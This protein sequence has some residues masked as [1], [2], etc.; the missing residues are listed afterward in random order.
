MGGQYLCRGIFAF[1]S[2]GL[3]RHSLFDPLIHCIHP[4]IHPS[5]VS[6]H[7]RINKNSQTAP[8]PGG[9]KQGDKG[10]GGM[11]NEE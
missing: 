2:L 5:I 10:K 9:Q 11:R 6:P 8:A 3:R 7:H 1:S 4:P